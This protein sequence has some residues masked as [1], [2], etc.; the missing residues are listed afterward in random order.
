MRSFAVTCL[1]LAAI[2]ILTG[3]G[4]KIGAGKEFTKEDKPSKKIILFDSDD[5]LKVTLKLDLNSY[6]KKDFKKPMDGVMIF[7]LSPADSV[8]KDVKIDNHGNFRSTNCKY[9][10]LEIHFKKPVRAYSDFGQIE[11][12][13]LVTCCEPGDLFD[14]YVLREFL[15]YKLYNVLTDTSYRVRLLSV[16]LND[17]KKKRASVRQYGFFI[18]PKEI[19]AERTGLNVVEMNGL[20]QKHIVP[21]VMDMVAIFNYMVSNYDWSVKEQHNITL[22]GHGGK[23]PLLPVVA[24]PHDFDGTGVVNAVYSAPPLEFGLKSIRDRYYLGPCRSREVFYRDLRYFTVKKRELM[25][26]IADVPYLN[27]KSKKDI[28]DYINQFFYQTDNKNTLDNMITALRN[29]CKD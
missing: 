4:D 2:T 6:F 19:L 10:P 1:Y 11:K 8:L 14:D 29:N 7:H 20:G 16:T 12:I 28:V 18:E 15:V 3:S 17:L 27:Q 5:I 9:P 26:I 21:S 25:N 22:L 23:N 24:V 13:R